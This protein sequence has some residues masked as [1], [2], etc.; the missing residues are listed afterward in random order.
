[1]LFLILA[2]SH[3]KENQGTVRIPLLPRGC[4][5]NIV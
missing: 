2:K 3:Y 5:I 4:P 1:M